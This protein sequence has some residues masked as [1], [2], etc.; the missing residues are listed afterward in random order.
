MALNIDNGLAQA[1]QLMILQTVF[2]HQ[3]ELNRVTP[4]QPPCQGIIETIT[5]AASLLRT[6][7]LGRVSQQDFHHVSTSPLFRV[8]EIH[9]VKKIRH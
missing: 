2:Y 8:V 9:H 1:A 3:V 5:R 4:T 7:R 6:R